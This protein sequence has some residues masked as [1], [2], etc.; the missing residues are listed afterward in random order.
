MSHWPWPDPGAQ[1]GINKTKI[2]NLN[3]PDRAR[4]EIG[5]NYKDDWTHS[6]TSLWVGSLNS[7]IQVETDIL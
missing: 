2:K 6:V 5:S 3:L 4:V 7:L 1:I